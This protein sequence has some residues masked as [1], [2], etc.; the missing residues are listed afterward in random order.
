ML[1][2]NWIIVESRV[3]D[4]FKQIHKETFIFKQV[5]FFNSV[6]SVMSKNNIIIAQC[7]QAGNLVSDLWSGLDE[8]FPAWWIFSCLI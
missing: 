5:E 3:K 6:M 8:Y 7:Y 1:L 4:H 2:Y